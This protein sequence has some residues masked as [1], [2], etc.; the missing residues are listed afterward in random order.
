MSGEKKKPKKDGVLPGGGVGESKLQQDEEEEAMKRAQRRRRR[1]RDELRA[2]EEAEQLRNLLARLQYAK[3]V[4]SVAAKDAL[5]WPLLS[6]AERVT[7]KERVGP[8]PQ[9]PNPRMTA[10][11]YKSTQKVDIDHEADLQA[12]KALQAE[13]Y[14]SMQAEKG[15]FDGAD[16]GDEGDDSP[17]ELVVSTSADKDEDDTSGGGTGALAK[18]ADAGGPNVGGKRK[19]GGVSGASGKKNRPAP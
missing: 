12:W 4:A 19:Q 8:A 10:R 1:M 15:R 7:L 13:V 3:Y 9:H 11:G 14:Q 5:Q 6:A 2:E 16:E 18:K 17:A